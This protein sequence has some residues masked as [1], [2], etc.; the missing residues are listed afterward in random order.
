V[1][2]SGG[3]GEAVTDEQILRY[4]QLLASMEGIFCEP[5]SAAAFAALPGLVAK[6]RIGPE[7]GVL[8]AVTGIGLKDV[9]ALSAR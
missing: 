6:G 4:Q 2:D 1:G 5:T 9:G 8:V 3:W 7:E